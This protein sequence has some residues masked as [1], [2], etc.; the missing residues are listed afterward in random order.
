[1]K[2]KDFYNGNEYEIESK[3][4]RIVGLNDAAIFVQFKVKSDWEQIRISF[5]DFKKVMIDKFPTYWD[6]YEKSGADNFGRFF[7]NYGETE[8][9]NE[10]YIFK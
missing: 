5:D 2:I 9:H 8:P 4:M 7:Y 3:E 6:E 10:T 1:M